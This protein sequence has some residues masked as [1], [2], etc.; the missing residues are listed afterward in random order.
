M[1][2]GEEQWYEGFIQQARENS[3]K[4]NDHDYEL[5]SIKSQLNDCRTDI[6]GI[7]QQI[8]VLEDFKLVWTTNLKMLVAIISVIV[9]LVT[10]GV[11]LV[12]RW[13]IK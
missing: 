5:K 10:G 12:V 3:N 4:L 13:V 1:A 9:A 6:N 8:R 11:E 7:R 2:H